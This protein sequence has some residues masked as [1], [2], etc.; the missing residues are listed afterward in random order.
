MRIEERQRR[1]SF[2]PGPAGWELE[3]DNARALKA[4]SIGCD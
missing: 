2:Q 1:P 3:T 4:R